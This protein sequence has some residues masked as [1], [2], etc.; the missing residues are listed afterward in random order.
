MGLETGTYLNDLNV[1]NPA[2]GD[3]R[4]EG[5][6][7][8]RLLK[9]TLKNTFPGMAGR[10]WR[11]Q[12]KGSGYT[13]AATD[14]MSVIKA[15]AAI[16]LSLTAV[17]TI[18]NGFTFL[19]YASSGA[20]VIDPNGAETVNG[21][22][23]VTVKD[24]E[25]WIFFCDGSAWIGFNLPF[26]TAL[27][28]DLEGQTISGGAEITSKDLGTASSGTVTPDPSAR[29]IQHYTNGGAHT[30]APSA[31]VGNCVVE[32]TNNASAGAITTSGFTRVT[33]DAFDTTNGHKFVCNI[34][35][36]ENYSLLQVVA[37]Q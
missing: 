22:A 37:M 20:V 11:S 1:S 18:G 7:H 13:V 27:R 23:T 31:A 2:T 21:A 30:L 29:P 4:S 25:F 24:G 19:V 32:I 33:G 8:L 14:M 3:S 9:N 10:V 16:T 35:I 26:S 34:L 12:S 28:A 15:T 6:D 5:D 17:A 36:T